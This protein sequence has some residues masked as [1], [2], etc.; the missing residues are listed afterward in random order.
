MEQIASTQAPPRSEPLLRLRGIEKRFVQ[1][2]D[3]AGRIANLFGA[4][5]RTAVVHA[6]TGVDLDVHAGEVIGVVGSRAAAR[7]RW[8]A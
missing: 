6:V 4:D 7:R 8:A 2:V 5:N 1:P 3:V